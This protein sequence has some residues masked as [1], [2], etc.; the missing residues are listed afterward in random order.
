MRLPKLLIFPTT[1]LTPQPYS[2]SLFSTLSQMPLLKLLNNL[3]SVYLIYLDFFSCFDH[4]LLSHNPFH[5]LHCT[6]FLHTS[7]ESANSFRTQ[8]STQ[9]AEKLFLASVLPC[10]LFWW[11][12]KFLINEASQLKIVESEENFHVKV[13]FNGKLNILIIMSLDLK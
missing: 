5:S 1:N 6:L 13:Y 8:E 12:R 3:N 9:S 2:N 11:D 7:G 10:C 4:H